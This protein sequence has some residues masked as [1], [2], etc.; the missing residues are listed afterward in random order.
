M[1][2]STFS[3]LSTR[4]D[5]IHTT[6]LEVNNSPYTCIHMYM[7]MYTYVHVHVHI[8]T[9]TCTHMYMYMYTYVHVHVY[10]IFLYLSRYLLR[11]RPEEMADQFKQKTYKALLPFIKLL[12]NMNVIDFKNDTSFILCVEYGRR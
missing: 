12:S 4:K 8:C 3:S 9:C 6:R 5:C 2:V 7:Y 10:I 11:N 1:F